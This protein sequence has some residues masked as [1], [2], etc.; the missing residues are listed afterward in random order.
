MQTLAQTA[1]VIGEMGDPLPYP[2]RAF[3]QNRIAFRR[4]Q[5]SLVVAGP[6]VGKTAFALD[7]VKRLAPHRSLY[8]CI[9]TDPADMAARATASVTGHTVAEVERDLDYFT[10]EL[11]T[12]MGHVRWCFDGGP[13]VEDIFDE[14]K[15]YGAV[16]GSWPEL[17]V[18]DNLTSIDMAG[19]MGY[20]AIQETIAT[21]NALARTSGAHVMLLHHA[22]GEYENGDKPI[23]LSGLEQKAGKRVALVLT[24]TRMAGS[25]R[26]HIVKNRGGKA[27]ARAHLYAQLSVDLERMRVTDPEGPAYV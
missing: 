1:R 19:E 6:G 3:E 2:Y 17:V 9:D 23:P 4:G 5:V 7:V 11:A 12:E 21:M 18:I 25:L 13:S 22:V 20:T 14:V 8:L 27:D 10:E 24:L 16:Y 15:A 26:V